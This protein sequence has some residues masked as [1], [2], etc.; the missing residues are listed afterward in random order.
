MDTWWLTQEPLNNIKYK[1]KK[2]AYCVIYYPFKSHYKEGYYTCFSPLKSCV[3]FLTCLGLYAKWWSIS[4]HY[5]P[6][7]PTISFVIQSI[8]CVEND[9]KTPINQSI[10]QKI[11]PKVPKHS[12]TQD[13]I[14][15]MQ[16]VCKF[17]CNKWVCIQQIFYVVSKWSV[18]VATRNF[19]SNEDI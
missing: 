6:P 14:C 3:Q 7:S 18:V 2:A 16:R 8:K 11:V 19:F 4:V 5:F 9:I 1:A 10:D 13:P 17:H 12:T 15:R